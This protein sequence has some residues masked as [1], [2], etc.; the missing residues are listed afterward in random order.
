MDT[1]FSH[2][3]MFTKLTMFFTFFVAYII[4]GNPAEMGELSFSHERG[5]YYNNFTL[6]IKYD[7]P[8]SKIRYTLDGTNPFTSTSAIVGNSPILVSID[9]TNS[10]DR[11]HAP[12]FIVSACATVSDTLVTNI[13]TNTYLFPDFINLLSRDNILPGPDW[14]SPGGSHDISYGMDPDIYNNPIYSGQMDEAF[15]S[16]PTLSLVTDL[17]NLFDPDSGIYVNALYH[18]KEWERDAS[19][20]LLNPDG[21]EGFQIN[22]GIRIRGGWSRHYDNPK[23]AFRFFFRSEYGKSKLNYP[24]FGDEGVD[25]FDK[26]DLRTSQNYSWSY[27]GGQS[28]TFLREIFSRDTQRDMEQPYTRSRYYHLFINGT[29]WGL[30][31][32]QERSEAAFSESYFGGSDDDYDV[33]KV[34]VGENFDM[35]HVEATDGTLDKWKELWDAGELGFSNDDNYFKVQGLNPDLSPN[36]LYDKLLDVDN[37][38]DY[39][40]IT[41]F[42]GDFDGP[43]SGFRGNASPNNFYAIY[44][45]VNPAGFKFFRH[46]GEHTLFFN[47]WG[48]DRTGP[49]PAGENFEDSNP[50]WIHQK[51]SE[52]KNYRLR[53]ADR[54]YKHF[55]NDGALTL[56]KNRDRINIRKSEIE[57]AIIAESARWGDSKSTTPLTKANWTSAVNFVLNG[58]LPTRIDVVIEQLQEKGLFST[59]S[60]PQFNTKSGV[61]DKG[62]EVALSIPSGEIY[63]TT[64]GTDPYSP[65]DDSNSNFNKIVIETSAVKKVLVPTS[66]QN[67]AWKS[68]LNYDDS[69]WMT[70]NGANGGVGYDDKGIYNQY[71]TLDVKTYMHESGNNP[72][73]SCY[74][75]IP[76]T[77][78]AV[79]LVEMNFMHLD[80]MVDDGFAAYLNGV[81]VA[82]SNVPSSLE[83]NSASPTYMNST[84]FTR[85]DITQ[86]SD[87]LISGENLLAIHGMNTSLQS[88]D[89]LI[90]PKLTIGNSSFGG[91]VSPTAKL[92]TNPIAI[93]ET[94][95]IQARSLINEEWSPLSESKFIIDEDLSNLK[96]T[97]LHYHPMD[98]IVSQ[99]TISG[100]EFE[101]IEL[102]NIGG[103]ELNLTESSFVNGISFTFPQSSILPSD[104]FV[105]IASNS[106]E[107]IN[108]YG[109]LPD[110]EYEGQLDN[111]GEKVVFIN[112]VNDTLFS[113]KYNDKLPWPEE[114]DGDGYSLVSAYRSPT[115]DPNNSTYWIKSGA[116]N[117]SPNANDVV[118]NINQINNDVPTQFS[119]EQN[120]PNPFNPSTIIRYSIPVEGKVKIKIFDILGREVS[121]LLD[122]NY[123]AGNYSIEFDGSNLSSGI[124]F[125]RL[126][127]GNF[128]KSMKMILLR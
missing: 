72:N 114:A 60:P 41:F 58:F 124:Y 90:L 82:E 49:Y 47:D 13:V 102:K 26:I 35:Y 32:T 108:R 40:I 65:I 115:G 38:I 11:D 110:G 80:I 62:T 118:S 21:T 96:I 70:Y 98:E 93:D 57:T 117:G 33:I 48:T 22:C 89:F 125:Y 101:F 123:K 63:F 83:W 3:K 6:E 53:F 27:K 61:V 36:P 112:A 66:A 69:N 113:F 7:G 2:K 106:V 95:T 121:T 107:F 42:A 12:G 88:S 25:K 9:P 55:Y 5:F 8:N 45:R 19:L 127:S 92:Y 126:R 103:T 34:D 84:D 39:M 77:V 46:D 59:L 44:N 87:I 29:Y 54:V 71:I 116:I 75:R 43:I 15:H 76:F 73:T 23:H 120:Y 79:D 30:Y 64:D 97:E 51:L 67:S 56:A 128:I 28:N 31:Q 52:N 94:T 109:F 20:E 14:L 4:L 17:G 104:E 91:S 1:Y 122:R 100:K 81:K 24:L 111:G 50:Q 74:I 85:F 37:L 86:H 68:D 18:S 119:L 78:D 99:D 105:I 16:I 10:T